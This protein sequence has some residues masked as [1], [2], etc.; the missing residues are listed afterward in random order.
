MTMQHLTPF[1]HNEDSDSSVHAESYAILADDERTTLGGVSILSCVIHNNF[2]AIYNAFHDHDKASAHSLLC[3]S[4][5]AGSKLQQTMT[6]GNEPCLFLFICELFAT[7]DDPE[8]IQRLAEVAKL[9]LQSL[10]YASGIKSVDIAFF[11]EERNEFGFSARDE[12]WI[13]ALKE[14]GFKE[15]TREA[16]VLFFPIH[17]CG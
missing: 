5:S 1:E 10:A 11:A 13:K 12:R 14:A 2:D 7:I 8:L 4:E 15:A 3:I 16:N 6:S 9:H 17:F